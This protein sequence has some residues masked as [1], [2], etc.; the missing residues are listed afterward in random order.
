MDQPFS[1]RGLAN[2]FRFAGKGVVSIWK[3]EPNFRVHCLI[4]SIAI[5]MGFF[6]HLSGLEW[7]AII[8]SIGFVMSA[9][10]FNSAIELLG[11][12]VNPRHDPLIGKAKDVSATAVLLVAV[13]ASLVGAIVYA[14]KI[15]EMIITTTHPTG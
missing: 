12:A 5:A 4:G 1:F 9:E 10:A 7:I 14:P 6:F 2:S 15:W 13:A 11:D 3:S 8:L